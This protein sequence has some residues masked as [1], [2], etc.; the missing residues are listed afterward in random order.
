MKRSL[1]QVYVKG[2]I[3]AVAFY[4]TAFDV[5]VSNEHKNT[6]GQYI[7]AELDIGGQILAISEKATRKQGNNMQFCIQ[8]NDNEAVKLVKTFNILKEGAIK[9]EHNCKPCFYSTLMASLIDKYGI[10]WCLF[11]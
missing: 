2:S 1:M 3:E 8:Y 4:Q 10:Y 9:I 5:R 6:K 11:V 7:H